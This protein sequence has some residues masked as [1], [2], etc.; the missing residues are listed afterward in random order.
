M[1]LGN[2]GRMKRYLTE[3]EL[4]R[5]LL[6][7]VAGLPD[8]WFRSRPGNGTRR[9]VIYAHGGLNSES[10]AITRARAM[11]RH[12]VANGCWPIFLVWKTGLLESIGNIVSEAWRRHPPVAAGVGDWISERTDRLLEHTVGRPLVRP[13]WSE[14]KENAALAFE[15]GR[16]GDLLITALRK[17]ADTW[18][19]ALELHL[20]GHSAGAILLGHLLSAMAAR[21][22][23]QLVKSTHLF[24]PACTVQFANRHYA[25]QPQVMQRL[26]VELLSDRLEREDQVAQVYRK[27]LLYFVSNALES[28]LRTPLLGLAQAWNPDYGGWDGTSATGDTLRAWRDA[29]Q[30]AGLSEGQRLQVLDA[31]HVLVAREPER[32]VAAA[33][34]SFDNDLAVVTR[35][36][37]RI[38][39]AALAAPPDDLRGF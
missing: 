12:F 9:V 7:Q 34:G 24:A 8:Q 22:S 18:G 10:A 36:L 3:D 38:T 5:T 2:D 13:I 29:A 20:V 25:T 28:D 21:Q 31:G 11:G 15:P 33:H 19:D 6:H 17:L 1:V 16:G 35:T 14:M 27:S 32:R 39:G 30:A 37:E 23:E 26:H 4:S